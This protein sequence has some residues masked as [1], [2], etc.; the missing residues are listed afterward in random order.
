MNSMQKSAL[1][2]IAMA[3]AAL[4]VTQAPSSARGADASAPVAGS[5]S[6]PLPQYRQVADERS[7]DAGIP[8]VSPFDIGEMPELP[9]TPDDVSSRASLPP[10]SPEAVDVVADGHRY[11]Y[12]NGHWYEEDSSGWRAARPPAGFVLSAIPP[13]YE[14]QWIDGRPYYYLYGV[15]Y[16]PVPEGYEVADPAS[17]QH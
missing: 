4:W 10:L 9:A 5:L 1:A 12:D 16:V 17:P 13:S 3:A 14:T 15:Y 7:G 2:A 6:F 11:W 8:P